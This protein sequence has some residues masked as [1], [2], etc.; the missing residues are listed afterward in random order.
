M[1]DSKQWIFAAL[2]FACLIFGSL[3]YLGHAT[4]ECNA[5][6]GHLAK[7]VYTGVYKCYGQ[8]K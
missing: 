2:F 8:E 1:R 4:A 6:H 3:T 5:K 7:D